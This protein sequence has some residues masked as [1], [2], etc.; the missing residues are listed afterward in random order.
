MRAQAGTWRT[1]T[2]NTSMLR[3]LLRWGHVYGYFSAGQAEMFPNKCATVAPALKGTPAPERR[4]KGR[5]VVEK[6]EHVRHED[7]PSAV[8]VQVAATFK[9]LSVRNDSEGISRDRRR[10]SPCRPGK[11]HYGD[12]VRSGLRPPAP[13]DESKDC[14]GA[15][16]S[17]VMKVG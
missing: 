2:E 14:P 9:A 8:Q 15:A 16:F 3:G 6:A 5:K 7:A 13:G 11:A 1:V 12:F 10:V 4:R 17:V